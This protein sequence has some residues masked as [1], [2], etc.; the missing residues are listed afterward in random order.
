[1][2][3]VLWLAMLVGPPAWAYGDPPTAT[4]GVA[5]CGEY[6][7]E[8]QGEDH[9]S[10]KGFYLSNVSIWVR[11]YA[12]GYNAANV[13]GGQPFSAPLDTRAVGAYLDG[14]C[15]EH[16][17]STLLVGTRCLL[18]HLNPASPQFPDCKPP[19]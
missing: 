18:A 12:T 17:D 11:G 1:M 3:I 9:G 16:R 10:L 4:F 2:L 7:Q 19:A 6:L 5:D 8:R 14:F 15:R 13:P